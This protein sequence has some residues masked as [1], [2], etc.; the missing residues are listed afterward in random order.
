MSAPATDRPVERHPVGALADGT[1]CHAPPGVMEI[2]DEHARCHLCGQWFRSV[3]AHLRSHGWDR[4]SYRTAFG[5]E[6][7]QSLEGGTTRDRRARAMRRRRAHDPVVRA[8]CEIGRRWASTGELTRA[9][10]TAAR[11]RRQPE[12]RRRKTLRTLA[13]IP[14]DVRTEAAARASVSRL[15]AIAETM[16]TD[17]GFRSFAEFIR[18]RVAAG[19]SL[20]RLSREAGLHK[21][22]LTRHL[23]TVDADLA[24]DLAS[25]VGGPCPPRHD[26]RLLARIVGLGFRDVASYLRQ[27]HLDE[28]RSV[29]AIATE[30][31]MNP[32]SVRA[33]MTRHGVPRTPHAPSRQRTAELARSVAHAHG[34]DDLDDYLTDRRRAGWTWQRIAAES[35]RPP[36]WLRRRARSDMS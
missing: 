23:G 2:A 32:Q 29:R 11:G 15:R 20:A 35:G 3:G 31:E 19:D 26:A 8:G 27:R 1:P 21:D 13:S 36:T 7:G 10:A 25:D 9:A 28:H 17:A 33:A 12:Q 22:W 14:V 6:R 30:V 16:A 5:L 34:F 24:A 18:T 4:A